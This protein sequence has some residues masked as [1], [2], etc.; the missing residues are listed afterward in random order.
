[1]FAATS[2]LLAALGGVCLRNSDISELDDEPRPFDPQ[3]PNSAVT[4][5]SIDPK[6]AQGLWDLSEELIKA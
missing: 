4:S 6:S 2:P 5:H 1:M 3:R